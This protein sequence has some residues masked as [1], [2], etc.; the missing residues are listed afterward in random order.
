MR[1]LFLG[2]LKVRRIA[3]VP[4][5]CVSLAFLLWG[6]WP[7][8][9]ETR[10]LLIQPSELQPQAAE[11]DST[12][13]SVQPAGLESRL[14]VLEWPGTIRTGDAAVIRLDLNGDSRGLVH[15][16]SGQGHKAQS[17]SLYDT[18]NLVAEAFFDLPEVQMAPA[19]KISEPLR[20]GHAATFFW[21]VRPPNAGEYSGMLWLH[22]R[23]VPLDGGPESRR[24]LSAQ[25]IELHSTSL[26]GMNG[27]LARM[28]GGAGMV[29]GV[30][31]SFG[32][33]IFRLAGRFLNRP[34][35][36]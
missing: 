15:P 5:L 7:S 24:P 30:L 14:I 2:Y 19:G 31:L 23:F 12:G 26:L 4:I 21:N 9:R 1:E 20:P 27:R 11:P 8:E 28:L 32:V 34:G 3:G 17:T 29:F 36:E 18:H 22:L 33:S 6:L 25:R 10:T 16:A 13:S 35:G